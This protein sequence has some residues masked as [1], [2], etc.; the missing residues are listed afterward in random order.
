MKKKINNILKINRVSYH[1][2]ILKR[3]KREKT[4]SYILLTNK[5]WQQIITFYEDWYLPHTH[6]VSILSIPLTLCASHVVENRTCRFNLHERHIH[7][8]KPSIKRLCFRIDP[9][10]DW[11][12][13]LQTNEGGCA[14]RKPLIKVKNHDSIT[15]WFTRQI[16][17]ILVTWICRSSQL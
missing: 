9:K 16:L 7:P 10:W 6:M 13:L 11:D 17:A 14:K 8:L 2:E 12:V 5:Q 4:K 3:E 15:W 1:F